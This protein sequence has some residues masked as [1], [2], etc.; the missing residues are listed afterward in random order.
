MNDPLATPPEMVQVE[1]AIVSTPAVVVRVQTVSPVLNPVPESWIVSPPL[2]VVGVNVRAGVVT[3]KV[4]E[5]VVCTTKVA[6][7]NLSVCTPSAALGST[8]NEP[9]RIPVAGSTLH[10]QPAALSGAGIS[11]HPGETEQS[12]PG[13]RKPDPDI[14]TVVPLPPL[15]ALSVN[16]VVRRKS[17]F[18]KSPVVPVIVNTYPGAATPGALDL[19]V[20]TQGCTIAPAVTVH[21]MGD[22]ENRSTGPTEVVIVTAVSEVLNPVEPLETVTLVPVGPLYGERLT[23]G[24]PATTNCALAVGV[25]E[26]SV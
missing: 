8:V 4:E 13:W 9:V 10:V 20:K 26:A 7:D 24:P 21:V 11:L 19:T 3:V 6:S 16:V 1:L 5:T 12:P 14:S 2:P 23:I 22:G 17:T 25:P 15:T 18:A